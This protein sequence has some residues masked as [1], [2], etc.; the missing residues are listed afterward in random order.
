[1]VLKPEIKLH[2]TDYI[3]QTA[4]TTVVHEQTR[5]DPASER[6][7]PWHTKI[8]EEQIE[9]AT[10]Q[11][12][13][14]PQG[15][16][17]ADTMNFIIPVCVKSD[18]EEDLNHTSNPY[19]LQVVQCKTESSSSTLT[20]YEMDD[21]N[22]T[23]T[24]G[25]FEAK[26]DGPHLS[27]G[28]AEKDWKYSECEECGKSLKKKK[29]AKRPLQKTMLE[30][31]RTTHYRSLSGKLTDCRPFLSRLSEAF[32]DI[33]DDKKPLI[34]KMNL[35]ANVELVDCAFGKV[36]KGCP[37]SYQC[38]VPSSR[39]YS[40]HEDAPPPPSLPLASHRL[41]PVA[42]LPDL[43]ASE[44]EL[45]EGLQ[46]SWDAA[47]DL[48][49][50]TCGLSESVEELRKSRLTSRFREICHLKSG[51]SHAQHLLFKIQRETSMSRMKKLEKEQMPEALREYCEHVFVNWSPCGLVV[52]PDAPWLGAMPHGLVYDPKES[53][54]YGLVHVKCSPTRSFADCQFLDSQCGVL[55][56]KKTHAYYWQMQGEMMLTGTEWC[57]LVVYT[58]EDILV[59]RVYRDKAVTK[60]MKEKLDL[61]FFHYYLPS[62]TI[63]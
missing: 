23:E 14:Q 41:E 17:E 25:D 6:P 36:P 51:R 45:V 29:K 31:P 44:Q 11:A 26:A 62:L 32:K 53:P 2:R 8:K 15:F 35:T 3:K 24:F 49:R 10:S 39:D 38:P 58:D 55:E 27:R 42:A 34:A 63:V 54:E 20:A 46:V 47:H 4:S 9:Y 43:S 56:L 19:N 7:E 61:F 5:A 37:L 33:P 22:E 16:D 13:Q 59:Q 52:H 30:F 48:E 40:P 28:S 60:A 21:A 18:T 50:S 12:E 57:D 1:M